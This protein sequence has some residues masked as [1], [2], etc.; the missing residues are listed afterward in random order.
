M[1]ST[2]V[3]SITIK[4][5]IGIG[6]GEYPSFLVLGEERLLNVRFSHR[7]ETEKR[8]DAHGCDGES[9]GEHSAPHED[10]RLVR[11]APDEGSE[12]RGQEGGGGESSE[13]NQWLISALP[14]PLLDEGLLR[15]RLRL[16]C[17]R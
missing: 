14:H 15:R 9:L 6:S 16:S 7:L 4:Q 12:A 17:G 10:L 2:S 13:R 5:R 8:S 3:Y 1:A 11:L